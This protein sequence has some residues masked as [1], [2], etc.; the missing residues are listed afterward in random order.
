MTQSAQ[1]GS[2]A[3][4]D[5]AYAER[6]PNPNPY[7]GELL[8]KRYCAPCHGSGN[9]PEILEN[10][11]TASDAESDYYIIR[12][13]LIDM[14]GFRSRLTK[15]QILDILA[16]MNVDLSAF[17]PGKRDLNL[18]ESR[19]KSDNSSKNLNNGVISDNSSSGIE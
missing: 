12:Y 6:A 1:L 9:A 17:N 3:T 8:Y 13:G 2:M 5:A 16:Y 7:V 15:F 11:V 10:R 4:G 14:K 18:K 19:Q